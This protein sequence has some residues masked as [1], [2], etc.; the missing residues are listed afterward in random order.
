MS[1]ENDLF[2]GLTIMSPEEIE[3]SLG[4]SEEETSAE[5]TVDETIE[6]TEKGDDKPAEEDGLT[7]TTPVP[8]SIPED[9][10]DTDEG[11]EG[12]STTKPESNV[13]SVFI[14]EMINEG[15]ISGPE[16]EE[17]LKELLENADTATV[18]KLMEDTVNKNVESKQES[19][20][21]SLSPAKKKFLEIEGAF[22]ETDQ[23]I[24]MAQRLEFFE[25]VT[26]DAIEQDENL[27][28][29]LYYEYLKTK[30][31]S[32]AEAIEAI[33][34]ASS[35]DKLKDKALKS[36][37]SLKENA[38]S[39]V[40][41]SKAAREAAMAESANK[42]KEAFEKLMGA[43][44]TKE[45]FIPNLNLNKTSREKLKANITTPVYTD[46]E[47]R[48]Y[49][50]LMYKQMRNPA[51]F[52][53]LINYYDTLG[54]FDMSKENTFKPDIT[55][56]KNVAKT[57]ATSELEDVLRRESKEGVGQRN[58]TRKSEETEGVLDFLSRA[59][60]QKR[61]KK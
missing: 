16:E 8:S 31:F 52:E 39:V 9:T 24:Q 44:D 53:M 25:S 11:D 42:N 4:S 32:D 33:D 15:I 60:G 55:K 38:E 12:E 35:I 27:Q 2:D 47:G 29:N 50:S 51:E 30:G 21:K 41:Q 56:L 26:D 48:E 37:P 22:D 19:W 40:E 5:T 7:I 61:R 17:E 54:L 20:K 14:K 28:K 43:V 36:L 46:K 6:T 3:S 58:S 34:E 13:F 1:E 49:T 23:A 57:K 59:T 10:D 45:S 18:K